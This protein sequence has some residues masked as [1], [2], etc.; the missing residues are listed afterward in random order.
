MRHAG[1]GGCVE[2]T[3]RGLENGVAFVGLQ[4][5][6]QTAYRRELSTIELAPHVQEVNFCRAA[7]FYF[8]DEIG[9]GTIGTS[10]AV[11]GC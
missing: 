6:Q 9:D 5:V 8:I 7:V 1:N 3:A 11:N 10:R 2:Q 4:F